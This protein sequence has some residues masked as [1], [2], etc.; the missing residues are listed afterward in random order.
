MDLFITL[1]IVINT[2]LLGAY[3]HGIDKE[4]ENGLEVGNQVSSLSPFKTII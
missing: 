4:A 1:C 3:H 2:C